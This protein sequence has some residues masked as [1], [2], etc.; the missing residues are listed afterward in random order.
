MAVYVFVSLDRYKLRVIRK[1]FTTFGDIIIHNTV[2]IYIILYF[3][4]LNND[5]HFYDAI[6]IKY[7]SPVK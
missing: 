7:L 2:G 3:K 6:N 4:F 5:A 1:Y